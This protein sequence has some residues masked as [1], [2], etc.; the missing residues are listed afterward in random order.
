[1]DAK[2][3]MLRISIIKVCYWNI[4]LQLFITLNQIENAIV[5]N[6][7]KQLLQ[8]LFISLLL[9]CFNKIITLNQIMHFHSLI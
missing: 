4:L 8:N 6:V 9:G 3:Q 5:M 2:K 7:K 1:M